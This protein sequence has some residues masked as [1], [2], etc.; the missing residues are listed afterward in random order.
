M[1]Q[2]ILINATYGLSD[3]RRYVKLPFDVPEGIERIEV[4][5]SYPRFVEEP[6]PDGVARIEANIVDLGLFDE[7]GLQRGWTGSERRSVFVSESAATP[8]YRSG[9][10]R[11][12]RWA[13]GLGLYVIRDTVRVELTI[14]LVRR[15]RV[16]LAGDL[17]MH[18]HHS[19][20]AYRTADV[21]EYSRRAALDFVALTD[22]NNSVQNEEIGL[23]DGLVVIP[24]M[25][26]TNYRG[27]A[28][29]F[30]M[31]E[32]RG[33]AQNLFS[34]SFDEMRAV[35]E[36]AKAAGAVISLNHPMC[37]NCPWLFG[38]EGFPYDM[39]EV[40][41]G[42]MKPSDI[43]AVA[44]WH[45][46][47]TAGARLPAVGGSDV[48][49]HELAR[50]YGTPTTFVYA[51]SRS[52]RT[53]MDAL[54]A[55]RSFISQTRDG[56]QVELRIGEAGLGETAVYGPGLEGEVT[57]RGARKGDIVKVLDGAG[58]AISMD[59]RFGGT[60]TGRFAAAPA[61]FH[62]VELWREMYAGISMLFALCN[63]VYVS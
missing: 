26:Y 33:L 59:V 3:Q 57:V 1:T 4:D 63:P 40:W 61:R 15:T 6:R 62:R 39:V 41:N 20:G 2:E 35:F 44:W 55:G 37:D 45:S 49:R 21:L 56:P 36:S 19:D 17:H 14:R 28:N 43:R 60:F 32:A 58:G 12:G 10:I 8:G 18:T 5:Y 25:E 48:H 46:R 29:F 53:V 47:L 51:E 7:R 50:T 22:H 11:A 42:L 31:G 13:V 24:S 34:N 54:L 52:A 30:F 38:F 27:H 9:P 16:L 23:P